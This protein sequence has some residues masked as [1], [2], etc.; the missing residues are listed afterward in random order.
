[1]GRGGEGPLGAVWGG[2]G[3]GAPAPD[4]AEEKLRCGS[5][6][7]EAV[8]AYNFPFSASGWKGDGTGG[9]SEGGKVGGGTVR[10]W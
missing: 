10:G 5:T 3:G 2:G 7:G 4:Y 9:P 1:M 6:S 8:L